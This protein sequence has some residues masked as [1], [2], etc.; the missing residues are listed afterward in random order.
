M[1]DPVAE[2]RTIRRVCVYCA[3]SRKAGTRYLKAAAELGKHLARHGITVVCGGG[4]CGL[5]G[6]L[7]DAALGEGGRV[8]G[9]MPRF[10]N[11]IEWGQRGLTEMRLVEDLAERKRL[12]LE[13]T[14]GTLSQPRSRIA[15]AFGNAVIALPGGSGIL[16][17]LFEVITLKRL[18]LYVKPIVL[19]NIGGFFD[20]LLA[21]LEGVIREKSMDPR[22][23]EIWCLAD[24]P[25]DV[26]TTIRQAPPWGPEARDFALV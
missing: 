20:P 18:G 11:D 25:A 14:A 4:A 10:M 3:S 2:S 13:G 21:F 22:H 17:E 7:A 5:M 1:T 6:A 15:G 8:L 23:R 24:N 12:M 9:V 19:V 26:V 16:K